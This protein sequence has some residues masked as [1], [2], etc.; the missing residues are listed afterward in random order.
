MNTHKPL[1]SHAAIASGQNMQLIIHHQIRHHLIEWTRD[2]II[3]SL[4][5]AIKKRRP[6]GSFCKDAV[7]KEEEKEIVVDVKTIESI[8]LTQEWQQPKHTSF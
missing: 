8:I 1:L 6:A 4:S 5:R 7:V 2:G 3:K